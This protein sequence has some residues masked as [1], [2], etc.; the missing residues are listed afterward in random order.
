[1]G[2][3]K[4]LD[5]IKDWDQGEICKECL[6]KKAK[7]EKMFV[8]IVERTKGKANML[9]DEAYAML[10]KEIKEIAGGA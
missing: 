2:T 8:N 9:H 7:V 3:V 6:D 10:E 4:T 1:M 5:K